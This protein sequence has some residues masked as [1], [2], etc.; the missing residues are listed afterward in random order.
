MTDDQTNQNSR[1]G[2]PHGRLTPTEMLDE[3]QRLGCSCDSTPCLAHYG[4]MDD[5][6]RHEVLVQ[7]GIRPP[8]DKRRQHEVNVHAHGRRRFED[9]EWR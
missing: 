7:L 5:E 9:V 3:V 6:G 2:L 1:R 4:L 8:V